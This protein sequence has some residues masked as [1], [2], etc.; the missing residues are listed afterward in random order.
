MPAA[1]RSSPRWRSS[2]SC[3]PTT[4]AWAALAG[5]G[6][7]LALD[8]LDGL[9]ARRQRLVSAFGARFD[10]EVDAL[11]ILALAAVALGLGKA[12]PWILGLGLMRYGF[13]LAGLAV[14]ALARPLPASTR[15]RAVCALQ[16]ATLGLMLAPPLV[17][18]L[19]AALAA[20]AFA[21]L[22]GSFVVDVAWLL[23]RPR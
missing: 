23:R 13:V 7:L 4:P 14:P 2:R 10:M 21:A 3:S 16:V 18:P 20:T 11:L 1:R 8:G 22:A 12:G 6:L 15:R 9:A 17:P 19:A 5:A